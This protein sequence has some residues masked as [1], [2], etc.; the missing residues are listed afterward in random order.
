[1]NATSFDRQA[2]LNRIGYCGPLEP[3]LSTLHQLIFAHSH[4]IAYE[5]LDIMLGRTPKLDLKSLQS[6]MISGGR[7]AIAWNRTCCSGKA[8]VHWAT[9]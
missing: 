6:K 5:S 8:F 2:W 7:G 3:T 4:A 1:M 9:R